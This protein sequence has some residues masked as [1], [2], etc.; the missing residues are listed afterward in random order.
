M[1]NNIVKSVLVDSHLD[2]CLRAAAAD[3]GMSVSTLIRTALEEYLSVEQ[4]LRHVITGVARIMD[5]PSGYP[6]SNLGLARLRKICPSLQLSSLPLPRIQ[7]LGEK[8]GT[9]SWPAA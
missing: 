3:M 7:E 4:G 9:T 5:V 6:L 1:K 8:P 2:Q